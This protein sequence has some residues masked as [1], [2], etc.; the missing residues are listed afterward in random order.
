[1]TTLPGLLSVLGV[2][3]TCFVDDHL[4]TVC[5]MTCDGGKA[6]ATTRIDAED[7]ILN[8]FWDCDISR[9]GWEAIEG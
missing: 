5:E 3:R 8:K 1:M 9:S 7:A 2:S 6:I 4:S